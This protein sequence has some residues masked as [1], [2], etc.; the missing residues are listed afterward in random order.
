VKLLT[1][2]VWPVKSLQQANYQ[3]YGLAVKNKNILKYFFIGCFYLVAAC[4]LNNCFM[5]KR[6]YLSM[7]AKQ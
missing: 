2:R 4:I 6:G 1:V 7:P 3:T 5:Q